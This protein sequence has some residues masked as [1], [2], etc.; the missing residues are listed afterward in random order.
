MPDNLSENKSQMKWHS[1]TL[2]NEFRI[3]LWVS[4]AVVF[5]ICILDFAGWVFRIASFKSIIPGWLP[6]NIITTI[7]LFLTAI[8]LLLLQTNFNT[9]VLKILPRLFA[10]IICLIS[11]LTLYVLLY[12][13]GTGHE[14]TITDVPILGFF[15]SPEK[16]MDLLLS[17]VIFLFGSII[18]LLSVDKKATSGVAHIIIIPVILISYY[19]PVS[20]I[21]G[22]NNYTNMGTIP[23]P[24]NSGIAL[25]AA[26][27]VVLLL[28][29]HTWLLKV[30]TSGSL[31]GLIARRLIPAVMIIPVVIAWFRIRGEQSG[32]FESETG[33]VLVA[34]TYTV[35]FLILTW[36]L[37]R[38][39]TNIDKKR[40][41]S[42]EALRESEKR[43]RQLTENIPDLIVRS[44]SNLHV[45]YANNAVLRR[46]GLSMEELVGKT[47][48][49]YGTPP[50]VAAQWERIAHTALTSGEPQRIEHT[51][52]WQGETRVFDVL[53]VPEID[54]DGIVSSVISIARDITDYKKAEDR[55][56]YDA[57]ILEAVTD[58][59]IGSDLSLN[60]TYWNKSA[61]RI[62]GWKHEEVL[63]K[64]SKE[65]IRSE[66]SQEQRDELIKNIVHGK[67]AYT[68]LVQYTKD[69]RRLIIE[70]YTIPIKNSNGDI[71]SIVA[72]NSDITEKKL[73]EN[74]IRD[75]EQRLKYH[76][77]NSPLAVVEWDKDF[78]IIQW[79]GEAEKIF[80]FTKEEV[81]GVRIDTLNI[82]YEEDIPIVERTME[83]LTSGKELK[84]VSQNRNYNKKRELIICVWHNSVLIDKSGLMTSVMSLVENIT[85]LK[86]TETELIEKTKELELSNSRLQKELAERIIAENALKK[87]EMELIELN[88]TKNKFFNIIAHDLKNPFTS[89]IGSSELLYENINVLNSKNIKK[90]ASILN[91]SAKGGYSILQNLLDWSRSQTGL[92]KIS[93]QEINLKELI[94]ENISNLQLS[95]DNKG[96]SLIN[97]CTDE[98]Y[99]ITD[100]NMINTVLR[101]LLSNALKF[102]HKNGRVIVGVK[103]E[104][105][106]FKIIVKDNGIGIPREKVGKLFNLD[107]K[108]STPGTENEQGTGL[109]LKLCR[110]FVEK[111]GGTIRVESTEN[112]GSEFSITIPGNRTN[113]DNSIT[114]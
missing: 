13:L 109:G 26:S 82:I 112:E 69:N 10:V 90:L 33:V 20:Y 36:F 71:T 113:D 108:N 2:P 42:E 5:M 74:I 60:I 37:A 25:F 72:I 23:M 107:T 100:K 51:N 11:L 19:L 12:S 85:N 95:A 94:Y 76:L 73:A 59:I 68:E 32:L 65:I 30:F 54:S 14:S 24:L 28:R 22:I 49:E 45:L 106:N 8:S 56:R 53:M 4:F 15:I 58:A 47:A 29:P 3:A 114:R 102:T 34:I 44:D 101:N 78:R 80:G 98:V 16:R 39:L 40:G 110:E 103:V 79:S 50:V 48:T 17:S 61:E 66:M 77:E 84:V 31:G 9:T 104:N 7:C 1:S 86:E 62:Y 6:M 21:L 57:N 83:R 97:E 46:T 67:A 18:I 75:S 105:V 41:A 87:S 27:I 93:P 70:G 52:Y 35:C 89:L 55:L 64:P 91:D 88:A 38:S 81:I 99:I 92:L 63:G 96:I 43:Y 111:L